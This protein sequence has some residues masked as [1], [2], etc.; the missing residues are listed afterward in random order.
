M[1]S[2]YYSV[3]KIKER[4]QLIAIF[5]VVPNRKVQVHVQYNLK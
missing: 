1:Q 4:F 2:F 5:R 3:Q